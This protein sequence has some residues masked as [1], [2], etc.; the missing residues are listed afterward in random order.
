MKQKIFIAALIVLFVNLAYLA[1]EGLP[2]C[3][4]CGADEAPENLSWETTIA[5]ENEPGERLVVTGTVYE[6]DGKT[7]ASGVIIYIYHTNADGIYPKRGDETG[8]GKRHGY[9]RS[10][11]KTNSEGKYKINTIKP[12][13]YPTRSEPAHIHMTVKV[14]GKE[15]D[16]ID[17]IMFEDD[18]LL[19]NVEYRLTERGG[20]GIVSLK[21]NDGGHLTAHRDIYLG[22]IPD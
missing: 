16:W 6:S 15:E 11:L 12:A 18:P 20:S 4:W 13:P 14:P 2:E 1:Q 22:K 5:N 21:R 10:W 19:K 7:P 8:N 17:S 9:L 3:E